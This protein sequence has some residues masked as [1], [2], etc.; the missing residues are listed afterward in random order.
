MSDEEIRQHSQRM[1]MGM[2]MD[3]N[4]LRQSSKM[5]AGMS[6]SDIQN[7]MNMAGKMGYNPYQ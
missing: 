2:N 6:S 7:M 4:L 1:G 3:P 5:M